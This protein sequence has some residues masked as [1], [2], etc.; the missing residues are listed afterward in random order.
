MRGRSALAYG[1]AI[2]ASW[3]GIVGAIDLDLTSTGK[4]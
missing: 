1:A 2:C 4:R 3:G